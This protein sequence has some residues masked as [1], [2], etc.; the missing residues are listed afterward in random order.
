MSALRLPAVEIPR[1]RLAIAVVGLLGVAFAVRAGYVAH[2]SNYAPMIDAFSYDRLAIILAAGHGWANHLFGWAYRPP[3]YPYFLAGIYELVGLPGSTRTGARLVQELIVG[4]G[5]VALIGALARELWGERTML[6]A[7]ALAAVYL[8]LVVVDG[9]LMT[10]GLFTLLVITATL[11]AVR[12]RREEHRYPWIVAA[13]VLAGL[14]SL[15]RTNGIAV[16]LA[17]GVV[18]WSGMPRLSWRALLAPLVTVVAMAL[19]IAP[20][21]IRNATKLHDFVP[22]TVE[23]GPTL[24]GTYNHVAA[25]HHWLWRYLGYNDYRSISADRRLSSA[26]QDRKE[27]A[28]VLRYI[29]NHPTVLPQ[30]LFWNTVRLLDLAGRKLSHKTARTDVD[31]TAGVADAMTYSFWAMGALALLGLLSPALRRAPWSLWL[32]PAVLWLSV[33]AVT[34]G[35]PRFRAALEPFV[36]MVAALGLIE[37]A[38]RVPL[39]RRFKGAP[40]EGAGD[41]QPPAPH[42]KVTVAFG[43]RR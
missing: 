4:V 11:C 41:A 7:M 42:S 24:T 35:T 15:T 6:V 19:T 8:P 36:I 28:A 3:G 21:T 13:G 43:A 18:V 14:A 5:T 10:E 26:Q 2:T 32:V 40:S 30:V 1:P 27:T 31:A 12:S 16:G 9:A 23:T 22:V 20:W 29:A 33:A 25:K 34:T 17:L 38:R 39:G 37:V